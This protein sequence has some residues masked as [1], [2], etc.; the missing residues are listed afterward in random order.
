MS[1]I[2]SGYLLTS[3]KKMGPKRAK[4]NANPEFDKE[5]FQELLNCPEKKKIV[6][7]V[8]YYKA[9]FEQC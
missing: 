6:L 4:E 5:A 9:H 8:F 1:K 3:H 2:S 7:Q